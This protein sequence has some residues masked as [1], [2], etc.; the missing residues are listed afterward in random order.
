M[1]WQLGLLLFTSEITIIRFI[2]E[3]SPTALDEY[4]IDCLGLVCM[5]SPLVFEVSWVVTEVTE[6]A[7]NVTHTSLAGAKFS[8]SATIWVLCSLKWVCMESTDP[9]MSL[10]EVVMEA[11]NAISASML[12]GEGMLCTP[13]MKILVVSGVVAVAASS[14]SC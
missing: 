13:A 6:D 1:G 2:T 7:T 10:T 9:L 11:I 12:V 8:L 14:H 3:C 4:E 5:D